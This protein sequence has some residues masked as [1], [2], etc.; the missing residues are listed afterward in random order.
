MRNLFVLLAIPALFGSGL[1]IGS[2]NAPQPVNSQLA[3]AQIVAQDRNVNYVGYRCGDDGAT[4]I[5]RDF[6]SECQETILLSDA[7]EF[8]IPPRSDRQSLPLG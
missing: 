5:S 4:V 2:R 1:L 3:D 6:P 8:P 7:A